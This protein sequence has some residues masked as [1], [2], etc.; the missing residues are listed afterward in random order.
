SALSGSK[1]NKPEYKIEEIDEPASE[2]V[3]VLLE[4]SYGCP[5]YAARV[6]KD[7]KITRS[8]FWLRKK[9]F[10]SGVRA[11]NN[12]VDVSNFV[13]LETGHPLHAFDYDLFSSFSGKP[14]KRVLV[15]RAKD[16]EKFTT[17]DE[18]ERSLNAEVLLITDGKK[19]VALAGIMGGLE[20][21]V[22]GKTR[23]ILLESA[24]FDPRVIR[25]GRIS[26]GLNTEA[27]YRFERGADPDA[28][29]KSAD[30]AAYLMKELCGGKVLKGVVDN[31][32]KPIRPLVISFRAE[33]CSAILGID[34]K[35]SKINEILD[36]LEIKVNQNK[37]DKLSVEIPNFRPDLTREIDLIE[38]VARI[39]G[40]EKIESNIRMGGGIF[41]LKSNEEKVK[42]KIKR[43]LVG[44]GLF[45][46]ITNNLVDP[47]RMSK[48]NSQ[49]NAVR[50]LNPLNEEHSVLTTSLYYNLLSVI[51]WN[52]N[53]K[54]ND[55]RLFELG[56][57]YR[58]KDE[59][60][61]E[62][63]F[64]LVIGL[65]G[66]KTPVFWGEK[67]KKVD[68]YD[69]KGIVEDLFNEL[70]IKEY[71]SFLKDME[72]F[73]EGV[74][75]EL[76]VK[77]KPLGYLG[78]VSEKTLKIFDIDEE[79]F[80]CGIDFQTLYEHI[81]PTSF[82]TALPRFPRVER[83][84]SLI[85]E[86]GVLSKDIEKKILE[87]GSELVEKVYLFDFYKGSQIPA[88]KKSLAYTIWY[89]SEEKTLTEEEVES[90]HKKILGEL[91]TGFG[92]EQRQ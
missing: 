10:C 64:Q 59:K 51:S 39:Y 21:E 61:T 8:P 58:E 52:L 47:L 76:K 11:I 81:P 45:E 63:K 35:Q 2:W 60:T 31:Y 77:G 80:L 15:R 83:D 55:L 5:R 49:T 22:T 48:I 46:I 74:S 50:I 79:V 12:V 32:P 14:A 87:I 40:Y 6:I 56:K 53:R 57:V 41:A 23:N 28:V 72:V 43:F 27:S 1:L 34:I 20:S 19:P 54:E 7:V 82:Y 13:L 18:T 44:K 70:K 88:G 67:V 30:R 75:A 68:Y 92:A 16:K 3:D 26:L 78:K 38:E 91:K 29:A 66:R 4:D 89:H 85:V 65:C 25:R 71:D 42:D 73:T 36:K 69:L 17:L 33:R 24:Y 86:E 9:L 62:E 90:V 84:I 37:N